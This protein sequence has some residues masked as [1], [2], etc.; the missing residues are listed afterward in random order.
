MRKLQW[1]TITTLM[2]VLSACGQALSIPTEEAGST[3]DSA[4]EKEAETQ[5]ESADSGAAASN[6]TLLPAEPAPGGAEREFSTDFSKHTV[7]DGETAVD[8]GLERVFGDAL[9]G[10]RLLQQRRA[11]HRITSGTRM[12][13]S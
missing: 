12:P 1:L 11:G 9:V 3:S 8:V 4:V 10:D 6:V 13:P 5:N 7:E 2:L